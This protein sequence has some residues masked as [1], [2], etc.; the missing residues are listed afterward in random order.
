MENKKKEILFIAQ[1]P[2]NISP[3][4]RFRFELYKEV[5]ENN[6]FKIT[7][8]S[9][10]DKEG[11]DIIH[12]SGFFFPKIWAVLKG[13]LKRIALLFEINRVS[14]IFL[15]REAAP[16]GPPVFEWL[17]IRVF[18]K[19]VIYDFDDAIWMPHISENNS[20]F[21]T[22]KSVKKVKKI[23]RWAYKISCGNEFLCNYAK[24]YNDN[25]IY[26]P[27]CVDTEKRHSILANHDVERI[28]I[29]WTGSFSTLKYL[30]MLEPVLKRLQQ[31]Y[32]F[33]IKVICNQRPSLNL[34]N[35]KYIEWTAQNEVAELATCQIGLMPLTD[36]EWSEG[37]C[38]FKLIQYLSLE[39]PAVSSSVGVNTL[40]IEDGINGFLCSTDDDWYTAIEKMINDTPL[41]K[42]MGIEGRKKIIDKY[43]LA[44]NQQVFLNIFS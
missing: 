18:K 11:Y 27:T 26:N 41:R 42:R 32:D 16:L 22:L 24:K 4:Q 28:T 14:F 34:K 12:Q 7:T 40:I 5:L 29:G 38:G 20:L 19:K 23:C 39:I 37:K 33:D 43:S 30:D 25:V 36:D 44:S 15:Q 1:Y 21:L 31:K 9:F 6:G 10:L 17:Y 8:H 13:Y 3:G 2:E 35:V